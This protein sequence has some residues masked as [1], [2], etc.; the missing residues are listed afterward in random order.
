[1]NDFLN[2]ETK[3][4]VMRA[5]PYAVSFLAANKLCYF[6][7]YI[8]LYSFTYR[9]AGLFSPWLGTS[10]ILSVLIPIPSFLIED[11]LAGAAGALLMHGI[12]RLKEKDPQKY[13]RL[14]KHFPGR[15]KSK[16]NSTPEPAAESF[17]AES[18]A[19]N[20]V[21]LNGENTGK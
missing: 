15:K 14:R 8:Y 20:V 11:L 7:R 17:E 21:L 19:L 3:K 13:D 1:M 6:I 9:L 4:K 16:K 18:E 10:F 12:Q 2:E 5:L